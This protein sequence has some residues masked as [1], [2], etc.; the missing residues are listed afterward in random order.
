MRSKRWFASAAL[1]ALVALATASAAAWKLSGRYRAYRERTRAPWAEF[2][3]ALLG[4]RGVSASEAREA[5][6]KRLRSV[7]PR[8]L[9]SLSLPDPDE[10]ER[11]AQDLLRSVYELGES[12]PVELPRDLTWREDPFR[13][14]TWRFLLHEMRFILTLVEMGAASGD[15][16]YL[17]RAEEIVL[18]W[19]DANHRWFLRRPYRLAW[20][21]HATALRARAWLPF[22]E[23]WRVSPLFDPE[24]AEKILSSI[25][26]HAKLLAD[27][28][29]YTGTHNHGIGQ[30]IALLA[31]AVAFPELRKSRDWLDLARARLARQVAATVSPGGVHLEHSPGYHIFVAGELREAVEFARRHGIGLEPRDLPELLR[32]MARAAAWMLWPDGSVVRIGDTVAWPPLDESHPVLGPLSLEEPLLRFALARGREGSPGPTA[33]FFQEEGYAVFRDTW[34]SASDF[35]RAFHL[36]FTAAAHE[37]RAHKQADDLSFV[38]YARGRPFIQD[39]GYHSSHAGDPGREYAL[40]ARAHNAVLVDGENSEGWSARIEET[41]EN[42]GFAFV[43]ASH[44]NY[45]G[46]RHRRT[47][48]HVRPATVIVVDEIR[49]T[50]PGGTEHT[51]DQLF[52]LA[53]ELDAVVERGGGSVRARYPG[54]PGLRIRQFLDGRGT[55]EIVR[56]AENPLQGWISLAHQSL[57]PAPVAIFRARGREA[58]FVTLIEVLEGEGAG[59]QPGEASAEGTEAGTGITVRWTADGRTRECRIRRGEATAVELRAPKA[60]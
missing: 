2:D 55:T 35:E 4:A 52:H 40:H 60:P 54:G 28:E 23:A 33:A 29:F 51:F 24:E 34:G 1:L 27:P 46:L 50:A 56:G 30:D 9:S 47:L 10:I 53:P 43:V 16:R 58:T 7:P 19:I 49:E 18:S 22:F 42:D 41:C 45:P 48:V 59:E 39:A 13:D 36:F 31:I 32:R 14:V 11:R 37:G 25:V 20:H 6:L 5:A 38:L 15:L 57:V 17:A 21:D 3:P 12:P 44:E 8:D 26:T